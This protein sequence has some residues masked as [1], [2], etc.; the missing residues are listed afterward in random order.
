[1]DQWIK[2]FDDATFQTTQDLIRLEGLLVG[3]SSGAALS[4][5]LAWLKSEAGWERVGNVAGK[6]VI[7]ILPDG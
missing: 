7:V 1:V 5:A 6:N 4:G 2:I 3:G